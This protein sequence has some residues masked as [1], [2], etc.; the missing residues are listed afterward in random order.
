[1]TCHHPPPLPRVH[2]PAGSHAQ[3]QGHLLRGRSFRR[4]RVARTRLVRLPL[5]DP[6]AAV[7]DDYQIQR[8]IDDPRAGNITDTMQNLLGSAVSSSPTCRTAHQ[9]VLRARLPPRPRP[10]V[11][12]DVPQRHRDS[13]QPRPTRSR[14]STRPT[15]STAEQPRRTDRRVISTCGARWRTPGATRRCARS[16]RRAPTGCGSSRGR[17]RIHEH[18]DRLAGGAGSPRPARD[19]RVRTAGCGPAA[20]RAVAARSQDAGA[21]RRIPVAEG[22]EAGSRWRATS[23]TSSTR[24]PASSRS[25]MPLRTSSRPVRFPDPVERDGAERRARPDH[26]RSAERQVSVTDCVVTLPRHVH[27]AVRGNP[28]T[29]TFSGEILHPTSETVVGQATL[30]PKWGFRADN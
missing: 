27:G 21:A 5:R 18:R 1:M 8:T 4:A 7:G 20:R 28:R 9:R 29:G 22:S 6:A 15:T 30:A 13:V 23:S 3:N 2:S 16:S 12:A 25:A 26:V 14:S 10:A 24:P 11:R 19:R 17:R